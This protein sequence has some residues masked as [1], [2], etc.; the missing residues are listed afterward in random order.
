MTLRFAG[1]KYMRVKLWPEAVT[2]FYSQ[3]EVGGTY[4]FENGTM[5]PVWSSDSSS[6]SDAREIVFR[7]SGRA[8]LVKAREVIVS[9]SKPEVMV[10]ER[11]GSADT[12]WLHGW[13]GR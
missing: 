3:L 13:G 6:T 2:R 10:F 7:D 11:T 12:R 9:A 1:Y 8:T 5:K 4:L